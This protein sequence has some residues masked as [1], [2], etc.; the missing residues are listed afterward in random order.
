[1]LGYLLGGSCLQAW[2]LASEAWYFSVCHLRASRVVL[3]VGHHWMEMWPALIWIHK[4]HLKILHTPSPFIWFPS[5]LEVSKT[6]FGVS[7]AATKGKVFALWD[8]SALLQA[9]GRGPLLCPNEHSCRGRRCL[10]GLLC[11]RAPLLWFHRFPTSTLL[12][13][14]QADSCDQKAVL[15]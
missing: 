7:L 11:S 9:S 12:G 5:Y 10:E 14:S 3:T 4:L 6:G 2:D 13:N 8:L 15:C 1:M